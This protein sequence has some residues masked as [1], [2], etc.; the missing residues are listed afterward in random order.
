[1]LPGEISHSQLLGLGSGIGFGSAERAL[2]GE[3]LPAGSSGGLGNSQCV[4]DIFEQEAFDLEEEPVVFDC[5]SVPLR[6]LTAPPVASLGNLH[7]GVPVRSLGS[8]FFRPPTELECISKRPTRAVS[9][10]DSAKLKPIVEPP[11]ASRA[12]KFLLVASLR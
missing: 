8:S 4:H 3:A 1:M 7:Y 10:D 5:F 11:L 2:P 6:S 9:L 12:A